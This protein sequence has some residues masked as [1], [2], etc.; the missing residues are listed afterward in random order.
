MLSSSSSVLPRSLSIAFLAL[1]AFLHASPV[2]ADG[3]GQQGRQAEGPAEHLLCGLDVYR[4]TLTQAITLFGQ[5]ATLKEMPGEGGDPA[6]S[7]ATWERD[8]MRMGVWTSLRRDR[9]KAINTID[10]W[11]SSS[12]GL[13]GASGRGLRLG[14]TLDQQKTIYGNRFYTNATYGSD[15]NKVESVLLEWHDGTQLVVDYDAGGRISHM[16]LNAV[17]Q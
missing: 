3:D 14:G 13:L 4:S 2:Q 16:Q 5:P 11:G 15:P 6:K 10:V 8:G 12:M 7:Y 1:L 17:A 9:E